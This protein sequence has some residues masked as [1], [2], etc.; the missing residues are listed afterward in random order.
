MTSPTWHPEP[1]PSQPRDERPAGSSPG[2]GDGM[3]G[4]D[5]VGYDTVGYDTVGDDTWGYAAPGTY[6][7]PPPPSSLAIAGFVASLVSLVLCGGFPSPVALVLSILGMKQTAPD[8]QPPAS[9][10]GL[11]IAGVVISS[12][13]IALFVLGLIW[14]FGI[15]GL[16]ALLSTSTS[17]H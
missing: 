12:V 17:V 7:V 14:M 15:M 1:D 10:R 4:Y 16:A 11:A 8:A 13:G 9:G 5:T 2:P 6:P 3:P